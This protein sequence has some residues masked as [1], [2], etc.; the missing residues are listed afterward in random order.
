[1]APRINNISA[2]DFRRFFQAPQIA[3][4]G[5]TISDAINL[6]NAIEQ[7][8]TNELKQ[9]EST[10][11][12]ERE[13]ANQE[14]IARGLTAPN[15]KKIEEIESRLSEAEAVPTGSQVADESTVTQTPQFGEVASPRAE[16]VGETPEFTPIRTAVEGRVGELQTENELITGLVIGDEIDEALK[17]ARP[18]I[19]GPGGGEKIQIETPDGRVIFAFR[20]D[21]GSV[22]DLAGKPIDKQTLSES[23]VG[24]AQTS[25]IQ[26]T[27][28]DG[29]PII[30][31][32]RGNLTVN[33]EPHTGP[34]FPN[35]G[36]APASILKALGDFRQSK[37][38]LVNIAESFKSTFVGPLAGRFT[39]IKDMVGSSNPAVARFVADLR[40]YQNQLIKAITGAQMGEPEA[41]RILS[42][43]PQFNDNPKAFIAKLQ[44][45]A[46]F[47]DTS[48]ANHLKALKA[49]GFAIRENIID[50]QQAE[51][52]VKEQ[53]GA[54][55]PESI[56]GQKSSA[57]ELDFS[58]LSD[59][60]LDALIAQERA[61]GN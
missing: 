27:N 58:N 32:R 7:R 46:R 12:I 30:R 39:R 43:M 36:R 55:F 21:D 47:A 59:E 24:F 8:R 16:V 9:R 20:R 14:R 22:I 44:V 3:S 25:I 50:D 42:Q 57:P 23:I 18:D 28:A 6:Q 29:L 26:G 5:L 37:T 2:E 17:I 52:L 49:G 40:S 38:M 34:V 35:L 48:M 10:A 60:E 15:I 13:I 4:P 41:K 33:G 45:A 51:K 19:V 61:G 1:M 11:K 31:D 53:F 54:L 56:R